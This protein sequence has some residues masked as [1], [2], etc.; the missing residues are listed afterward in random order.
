LSND[1]DGD[2]VADIAFFDEENKIWHIVNGKTNEEKEIDLKNSLLKDYQVSGSLVPMPSDYDGDSKTD[3]ALFNRTN[4]DWLILKSSDSTN[5]VTRNGQ[6]WP[7]LSLVADLDGDLKA[8]YSCHNLADN[9]WPTLLS[10]QNYV[11]SA[12]VLSTQP[13]DVTIYSDIDGDKKADYIV[14]RSTEAVFY[15]YLSSKDYKN[16]KVSLG[17]QTSVLVPEDYDG[18]GK[19]DLAVWLPEKGEWKIMFSTNLLMNMKEESLISY[20]ASCNLPSDVTDPNV[21]QTNTCVDKTVSL[22]APGDIPMPLDYDGDGKANIAVFHLDT[23]ELEVI[24]SNG[25]KTKKDFSKFKNLIPA[26]VLGI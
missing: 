16:V 22:G 24:L 17:E 3:I 4:G 18:D 7:E 13:V 12:K 9:R 23:Y 8:D 2:K 19:K 5:F 21:A 20:T 15:V 14:F 25:E 1:F 26:S 11:Y 10:T 6:S